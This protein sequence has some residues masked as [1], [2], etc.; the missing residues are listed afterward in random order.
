L[1]E[2]NELGGPDPNDPGTVLPGGSPNTT[3]VTVENM[4]GGAIRYFKA[5]SGAKLEMF[6]S[7]RPAEMW[8]NFQDRILRSALAGI[9][10]PYSLVWKATGQGTAERAEL[11]KAQRAVEDRQDILHYF[12]RRSVGY[13]LAKAIKLK[14][15]PESPDWW[16]WSFTY[17]S[18]LTIDDGRV[19]KEL[20]SGWRC[21]FRNHTDIVGM[22]GKDLRQ[23]YAER[24]EE[25]AMRKLAAADASAKYGVEV[26]ER[27]MAMLTQNEQPEQEGKPNEPDNET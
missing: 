13:A 2:W 1:L 25:V 20:E 27:E 11:G 24:A 17:P 18:K 9:N 14:L 4:A 3:G 19:A 15:L 21:G 16:R 22:M 5:G 23:H 7:Q 6:E 26:E 12:A 8:E 10:W